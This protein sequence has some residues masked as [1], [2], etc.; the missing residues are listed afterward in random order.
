MRKK[1]G[2]LSLSIPIYVEAP[3]W[4]VDGFY[5]PQSPLPSE[6]SR[7][8]ANE[9]KMPIRLPAIAVRGSSDPN[10]VI[11]MRCSSISG[12]STP[13]PLDSSCGT[14]LMP[15][16]IT[17]QGRIRDLLSTDEQIDIVRFA[18]YCWSGA[19]PECRP[20]VWRR[21]IGIES[22]TPDLLS[23]SRQQYY[24]HVERIG[25]PSIAVGPD[26][27]TWHQIYDLDLP[28]NAPN[29]A[30]MQTPPVRKLVARLLFVWAVRHP[31]CGYVQGVMDL[32][33]PLVSTFS[34]HHGYSVE[35][36]EPTAELS[37]LQWREV[38]AD[39]FFALQNL[40]DAFQDAY[41]TSQPGIQRMVRQLNRAVN[42]VAPE[43][44]KHLQE[45]GVDLLHVSFRWM[46][47]LLVRELPLR[48]CVRLFDTYL[49][50]I[51]EVG[52]SVSGAQSGLP[53]FHVF[54]CAALLARLG[55]EIITK[56]FQESIRMLQNLRSLT[57]SWTDEDMS[58]LLAQAHQWRHQYGSPGH[59]G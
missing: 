14:P 42:L 34:A 45:V 1:R 28:R 41:T 5:L 29:L 38:E 7:F 21:L 10:R 54:V 48:L 25:D 27:A 33:T 35:A 4:S 59:I 51:A 55:S 8:I 39:S 43:V 44:G 18:G 13:A 49:A 3:P 24:R 47:C 11:R 16:Q 40:L 52:F 15:S 30:G 57:E 20:S 23:N 22:H 12:P 37:D 58:V 36:D 53:L 19:P 9:R 2:T 17:N 50:E 6:N 26:Q 56:D 32:A 46:N 31:A